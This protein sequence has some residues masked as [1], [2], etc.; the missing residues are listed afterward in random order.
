MPEGRNR[1]TDVSVIGMGLMGSALGKA[2][3]DKGSE[4]TVWNRTES[5]CGPLLKQGAQAAP[6]VA[7]AIAASSL[8][9][10]CISDYHATNSL[11]APEEVRHALSGKTIV[12]LSTGTP[13]EARD[14]V[15]WMTDEDAAYLDGAILAFPRTIGTPEATILVSGSHS[16]FEKNEETLGKLGSI[17]FVGEEIGLASTNDTAGL[18]FFMATLMGFFHGALIFESEGLSVEDF[19][20][21]AEWAIPVLSAEFRQITDRIKSG[22]YDQTDAEINGWAATANHLIQVS[23]ENQISSDVPKLL[24]KILQEALSSGHEKHDIAAL[25]EVFRR[26]GN[27]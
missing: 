19:L 21:L 17:V 2:F 22:D 24:S 16:V 13:Q 12:Q 6:T 26:S 5:K 8:S 14:S 11:L 18:S 4:V 20:A 15:R 27:G 10:I 3:L 9:V 23:R 1:M 25:M 7:D